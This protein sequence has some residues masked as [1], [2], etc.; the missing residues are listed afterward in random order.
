MHCDDVICCSRPVWASDRCLC[1]AKRSFVGFVWRGQCGSCACGLR[2]FLSCPRADDRRNFM[3]SI[4]GQAGKGAGMAPVVRFVY[5]TEGWEVRLYYVVCVLC[6]D[7]CSLLVLF[8]VFLVRVRPPPVNGQNCWR[9]KTCRLL[10][11]E[12]TS[13]CAK[14]SAGKILRW[15]AMVIL[16]RVERMACLTGAW[17]WRQFG[18]MAYRSGVIRGYRIPPFLAPGELVRGATISNVSVQSSCGLQFE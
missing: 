8:A 10:Y 12:K 3:E 9:G 14:C 5:T 15:G 2:Q 17:G 16:A 1:G 11:C 4:R 6:K 13:V 7:L 18:E